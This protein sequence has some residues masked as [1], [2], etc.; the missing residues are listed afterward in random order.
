MKKL[1]YACSDDGF[2]KF[3]PFLWIA[4]ESVMLSLA[5]SEIISGL[6]FFLSHI[7]ALISLIIIFFVIT[8]ISENAEL[9]LNQIRIN[10]FEIGNT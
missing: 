8:L 3:G 6:F 1:Q 10:I 4:I 9:Q 5:L 7:I 2:L